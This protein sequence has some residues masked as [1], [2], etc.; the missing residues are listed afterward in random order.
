MRFH[1]KGLYFKCVLLYLVMDDAVGAEKR[2]ERYCEDDPNLNNSY[3]KKFLTNIL[4]VISDGDSEVFGDE[5]MKLN[6]RMTIDKQLTL[7]LT[8]IKSKLKKGDVLDED[9][10]PL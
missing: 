10:N 1:S 2:L 3:E 4:K 9:Y 6:S 8:E 7:I 5:C